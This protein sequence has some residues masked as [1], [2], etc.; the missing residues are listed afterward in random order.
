MTLSEKINKL[1]SSRGKKLVLGTDV[2]NCEMRDDSDGYSPYISAW[3]VN[4][5]G[6]VP[7]TND[8]FTEDELRAEI[9]TNLKPTPPPPTSKSLDPKYDW[10]P[11]FAE[12]MG[13][14]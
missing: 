9:K 10:G 13:E 6:P 4:E 8:G 5:L 7:T 1:V 11:R 2:F 12:V 14:G 3:S